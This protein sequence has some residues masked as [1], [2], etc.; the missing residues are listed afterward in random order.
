MNIIR[1]VDVEE[2]AGRGAKQRQKRTSRWRGSYEE[3]YHSLVEKPPGGTRCLG[4]CCTDSGVLGSGVLSLVRGL[5]FRSAGRWV[6]LEAASSPAKMLLRSWSRRR[7]RGVRPPCSAPKMRVC[8]LRCFGVPPE[9]MDML[10]LVP[11]LIHPL[12]VLDPFTADGPLRA[13]ER[14]PL[15]VAAAGVGLL[16]VVEAASSLI[17]SGVLIPLISGLGKGCS[18]CFSAGGASF[19]GSIGGSG[20]AW[21]GGDCCSCC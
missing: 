11:L 12:V 10:L 17:Q 19:G 5:P 2:Q 21:G 9:C 18:G 3:D 4:A 16:T 7:R 1:E 15:V 13:G 6:P 8:V 14:S 20:E